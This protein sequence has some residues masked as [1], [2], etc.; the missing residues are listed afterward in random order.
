[1][2]NAT[3]KETTLDVL[4]WYKLVLANVL[5]FRLDGMLHERDNKQ[6]KKDGLGYGFKTSHTEWKF[7]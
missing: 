2:L 5:K 6:N 3:T 4:F 1:M 7:L